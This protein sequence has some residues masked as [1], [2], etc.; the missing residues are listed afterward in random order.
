M[1]LMNYQIAIIH[2]R[3][4]SL[5]RH[6]VLHTSVGT[7]ISEVKLLQSAMYMDLLSLNTVVRQDHT[8]RI[9]MPQMIV[10]L[11]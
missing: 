6:Q 8:Q 3:L 11:R 10:G 2:Q 4:A 1:T 9:P 5:M 7:L